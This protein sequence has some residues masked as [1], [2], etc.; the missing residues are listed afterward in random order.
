MHKLELMFRSIC[1]FFQLGNQKV[2]SRDGI[3]L[4]LGVMATAGGLRHLI[5]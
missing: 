4:V 5:H 1:F 3:M 2:D